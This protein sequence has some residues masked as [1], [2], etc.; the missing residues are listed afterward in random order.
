MQFARSTSGKKVDRRW[1]K[2]RISARREAFSVEEFSDEEIIRFDLDTAGITGKD[3]PRT[4]TVNR[5]IDLLNEN[6]L[7][8]RRLQNR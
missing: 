1:H 6:G 4:Y 3:N 7:D 8:L 5:P 2:A